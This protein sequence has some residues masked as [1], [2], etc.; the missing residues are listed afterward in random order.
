MEASMKKQIINKLEQLPKDR[1]P[2]VL[3]FIEFILTKYSNEKTT[4]IEA[5]DKDIVRAIEDNGSLDFYYD[6]TQNIYTLE[7]GEPL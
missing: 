6:D 7:D 1:I 5:T 4:V 2:E 3:N